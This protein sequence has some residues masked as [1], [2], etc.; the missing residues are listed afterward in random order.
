MRVE[1]FTD[2]T[3][4]Q[5]IE[6]MHGYHAFVPAQLPPL[7]VLD[8]NLVKLLTDAERALS[9]LNGLSYN[10]PNPHLL[11]DPFARQEA[12]LSSRIEGTQTTLTQLYLFEENSLAAA[13]EPQSADAQ[14]VANYVTALEFGMAQIPTRAISLMLLR[15]MHELLMRGVRGAD[16]SPGQFRTAQ[17]HIG[18]PRSNLAT[19][20]YVPPPALQMRD[21]LLALETYLDQPDHLPTLI[22]LALVH[23]QFEAIHP[24]LDGNGRIGRLLMI[25]M[26]CRE[27]SMP[28]PLFYLSGFFERNRSEYYD[29]LLA[30]SQRGEWSAWIEFFLHGV[31]EQ[32]KQAVSRAERLLALQSSYQSM[33][34]TQR[35]ATLSLQLMDALFSSP[36]ISV[37]RTAR[38]LERTPKAVQ[39]SVER[40]VEAGI[41]IEATGR[42][43]NRVYIA[44][45]IIAIIEN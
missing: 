7:L 33:L 20:A 32:S 24:F 10:L 26:L 1:D 35:A 38:Q 18:S 19:A 5:L 44:P 34:Q 21:A 43:R 8:W 25:L 14:E 40:L 45:Q 11:I 27:R 31:V 30:V 3:V 41:L 16:K 9:E 28:H 42:E 39:Q 2:G 15:Q 37:M 23:Y 4:G 17:N 6:L 13:S 36:R 29:L 12:V 22:R